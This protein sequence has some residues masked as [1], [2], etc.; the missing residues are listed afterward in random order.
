MS[1]DNKL[2][3]FAVDT[4]SRRQY[5]IQVKHLETGLFIPIKLKTLLEAL[6]GQ[7]ITRLYTTPRKTQ[8]P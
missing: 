8:L 1:A 4:V 7:T 2:V 6:Y 5:V 3:A